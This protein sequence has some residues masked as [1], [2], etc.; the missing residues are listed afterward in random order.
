ML[1]G[2]FIMFREC[3][4]AGLLLSV[5]VFA[6]AMTL[7]LNMRATTG[8]VRENVHPRYLKRRGIVPLP[9]SKPLRIPGGLLATHLTARTSDT[10]EANLSMLAT[11]TPEERAERVERVADV[12]HNATDIVIVIP[13]RD[14]EEHYKKTIENLQRIRRSY[15]KLHVVVVEQAD[16]GYFRRGW[17]LNIGI[18]EARKRFVDDHVC[19]VTHDVDMIADLHVDYG[20]CDRPT[21]ICSELS[22]FNDGVPYHTSAGGVV[23]ASLK[24]WY[25]VNGFTNNAHGWGGEDDDLYHRFRMNNLLTKENICVALQRD[26]GNVFV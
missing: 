3:K 26:L 8:D 5:F 22:C 11:S 13:Y 6:Q 17:L 24:D 23:V 10:V 12:V 15:W 9:P 2:L 18:A 21:Q 16:V 25:T 4:V 20:W 1:K 7:L 14:R 19:V